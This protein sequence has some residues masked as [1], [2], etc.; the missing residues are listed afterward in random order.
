MDDVNDEVDDDDD[1]EAS[2]GFMCLLSLHL[3]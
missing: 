1:D 2:N 3:S